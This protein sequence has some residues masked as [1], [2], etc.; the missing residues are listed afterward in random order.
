MDIRTSS[1]YRAVAVGVASAALLVGAFSLGA[2]RA[3]SGTGASGTGANPAVLTASSASAG[4]ITVTGTGTVTGTPN[5]LTLSMGVQVNGV[6]VS[7]ALSQA[8]RVVRRVTAAL[9]GS[10]VAAADI[11]TSDLN[12]QPNYQGSSQVPVSYGVSESLTVTLSN[13]SEAGSQIDQAVNAGGNAATVDDV[14]VDLTNTSGLLAAAR[15][16]AVADAKTQAQQYAAA[17]G[18]PLG[19]VVS[20]TPVQ[21]SSPVLDY[22]AAASAAASRSVPISAG[23]QQLTVSITV[24]YAA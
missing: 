21:Q 15:A 10:G 20:V 19:P 3:T 12:V 1:G 11:Q 9:R 8:S 2:S 23:S 13:M 22:S 7:S 16:K 24:V 6:S 14:S 5:E 4:R 18:E 17:L